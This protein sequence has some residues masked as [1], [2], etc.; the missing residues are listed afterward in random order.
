MAESFPFQFDSKTIQN[1]SKPGSTTNLNITLPNV[2]GRIP[3]LQA[4]HLRT[5]AQE[6]HTSP[7]KLITTVGC[8]DGLSARLCAEAGFPAIF[9]GGFAMSSSLGLP[10]TGY[11][12]YPDIVGK[13]AEAATQVNVPIIVDGDTGFGSPMN[14]RRTVAGFAQAGAAGVMIE[15]QTWPKRCG[16]TEG[17]E[18]VS[19][20][21]A[22]ARLQAAVDARNEGVDIWILARTDAYMHG[23]EEALARAKEFARIGADAVFVEALPDAEWMAKLR[24]DVDFS[25]WANILEGG[26]TGGFGNG[27]EGISAKKIAEIG[28]TGTFYPI[29][30]VASHIVGIRQTLQHLKDSFMVSAPPVPLGFEEVREAVGFDKYNKGEAQYKIHGETNG[31]HA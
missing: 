15:D 30:L 22:Y 25:C 11:I 17:K 28:Y 21:E 1:T 2:R 18:V 14:V 9:L 13:I 27:K 23:Y 16:H 12:T 19:R 4:S 31:A 20:G 3:S 6:A 29:S 7:N 8:Y 24:R 10:D 5:L 26:K